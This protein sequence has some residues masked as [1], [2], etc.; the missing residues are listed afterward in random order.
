MV[1]DKPHLIIWAPRPYSRYWPAKVM[2]TTER[3]VYVRFFG[4]FH[5]NTNVA[6]QKCFLY[7]KDTPGVAKFLP[8]KT[9]GPN[10][11]YTKALKVS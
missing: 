8:W 3:E 4:G 5:L 1:C 11:D 9:P 10:I 6:V 7:S 2:T